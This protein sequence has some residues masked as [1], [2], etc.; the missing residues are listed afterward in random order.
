MIPRYY[1][2]RAEEGT[3]SVIGIVCLT[4]WW[5]DPVRAIQ[6]AKASASARL[7]VPVE[8]VFLDAFYR[9]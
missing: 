7:G 5:P 9:V 4:T 2:Y 1:L 3:L 8:H 6:E